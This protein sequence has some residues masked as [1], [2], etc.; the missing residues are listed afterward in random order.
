MAKQR[1][2]YNVLVGHSEMALRRDVGYAWELLGKVVALS[3]S[4]VLTPEQREELFRKA[5]ELEHKASRVEH[6]L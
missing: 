1:I 3:D 6:L 4:V 5:S 2:T